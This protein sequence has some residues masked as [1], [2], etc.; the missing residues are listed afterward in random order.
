MIPDSREA[1]ET[2]IR[3]MSAKETVR[4]CKATQTSDSTV[5]SIIKWFSNNGGIT[6]DQKRT[7][8]QFLISRLRA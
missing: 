2:A 5:Q 6:P 8:D 4:I 3:S 1:K 7:L